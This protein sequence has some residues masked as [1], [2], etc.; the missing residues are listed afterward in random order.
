MTDA[1]PAAPG[2]VTKSSHGSVADTVG[3]LCE[4][5]TEKGLKLFTLIDHSGEAR[6]N[7]LELRDTKAVVF[8]SPEAGTPV[9]HA[10]PPA[11]LDALT[12]ALIQG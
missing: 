7:G 11:A 3:R 9:I 1:T 4:I 10:A 8:G 12:D 2:V 6:A 5:V